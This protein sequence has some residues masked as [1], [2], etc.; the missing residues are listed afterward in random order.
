MEFS[1]GATMEKKEGSKA[2][3]TM[4]SSSNFLSDLF[5]GVLDTDGG[6]TEVFQNI[7]C[8]FDQAIGVFVMVL[9]NG[10]YDFFH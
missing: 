8:D 1:T 9:A 7:L 10:A 2:L 4:R 5:K 6:G 3:M